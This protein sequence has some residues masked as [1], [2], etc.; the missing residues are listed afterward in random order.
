VIWC[1]ETASPK[2]SI[3]HPRETQNQSTFWMSD[4]IKSVIWSPDS[5][6]H[7]CKQNQNQSTFKLTC[8]SKM[9]IGFGFAYKS[10]IWSPDSRSHF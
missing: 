2:R 1:P 7:L 8:I 5:R 10:V 9:L 6:S 4:K 3:Q